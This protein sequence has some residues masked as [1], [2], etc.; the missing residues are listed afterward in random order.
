[1][2]KEDTKLKLIFSYFN[3]L[4]LMLSFDFFETVDSHKV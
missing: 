4:Y 2:D 3:T 1:M